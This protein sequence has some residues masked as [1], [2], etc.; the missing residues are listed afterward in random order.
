M[1]EHPEYVLLFYVTKWHTIFCHTI[2]GYGIKWSKVASGI[3]LPTL[4][5][6]NIEVTRGHKKVKFGENAF[7]ANIRNYL[8]K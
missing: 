7:F 6:V 2:F 4:G 3:N 8:Q 5:H 1:K